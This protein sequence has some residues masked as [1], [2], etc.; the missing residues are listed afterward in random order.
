MKKT[1]F[2]ILVVLMLVVC[3][4]STLT[5]CN[6]DCS[7][8]HHY[9]DRNTIKVVHEATCD[10]AGSQT[11]TCSIC[12]Q[13]KTEEIPKLGHT[14]GEWIIDCVNGTKTRTCTVCGDVSRDDTFQPQGGH[15][16]VV[17]QVTTEDHLLVCEVCGEQIQG[18]HQWNHGTVTKPATC[19]QD[20]TVV[21]ACTICA[22]EKTETITAKGHIAGPRKAQVD[23]TCETAGT[24]AHFQCVTCQCYLDENKKE[25][26]L[27]KLTIEALG[28]DYSAP[29]YA[30]E[31]VLGKWV[32]AAT[33]VCL[34][35]ASHIV[36][37]VA[38]VTAQS[39]DATCT[40][41]GKVTYTA[42]FTTEGFE[43]QTK[44]VVVESLGHTPG[45]A[46]EENRVEATCTTAG[47]YDSV[48]YCSVC[49][50]EISR[51]TKTIDKIAHTEE[52]IP[53]KAAT[54]TET[55]L[56]EGKKCSVCDT[57]TTAQ[58]PIPAL[59][60]KDEDPVDGKCDVC[61]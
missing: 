14:Y 10:Q 60:H 27:D 23:A 3:M 46:V 22:Y 25:T 39:T 18:A 43:T 26:T 54:C 5:A 2:T 9:W 32:C 17:K 4:L 19:T 56:T 41:G 15:K 6:L 16:H 38:T 34:R 53:G 44:E 29:A 28:H 59:G 57:V 37:E 42:T 52:V 61:D 35:D 50:E 21:Y 12:G 47:S 20:G 51:E 30:W 36:S 11:I 8:G 1:T 49:G 40:T 7:L 48:V 31:Q 55:G 58:Q 45:K 33:K 24:K 13:I